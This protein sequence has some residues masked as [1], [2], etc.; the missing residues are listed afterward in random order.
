MSFTR[1]TLSYS[2]AGAL[3]GLT[4]ASSASAGVIAQT[5]T[6]VKGLKF[7][8]NLAA[9][10][11][12][13]LTTDFSALTFTDAVTNR[14]EVNG[15]VANTSGTIG[16]FVP[17]FNVLAA[18][19]GPSGY[20]ENSF[21]PYAVPPAANFSAADSFLAGA[22][23]ITGIVAVDTIGGG[24]SQTYVAT[25]LVSGGFLGSANS[26]NQLTTSLIFNLVGAVAA[27]TA[28][29]S[30][31]ADYFG[32]YYSTADTNFGTQ[33]GTSTRLSF[34]LTNAADA[35]I[36]SWT[37]G[38]TLVGGTLIADGGCANL[39]SSTPAGAANQQQV[40]VTCANA[41]YT[42]RISSALLQGVQYTLN[43]TQSSDV[44][45]K[46]AVPEPGSLALLGACLVGVGWVARRR[47]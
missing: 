23:I 18:T 19:V 34:S 1:K 12:F 39:N 45:A 41:L 16:V 29:I 22:P 40:P 10:D 25:S 38:G 44:N 43:I 11:I 7:F 46:L 14:A 24:L 4:I 33:G 17:S 6:T 3:L 32:Q 26:T 28:G 31:L 42:A 8:Q 2:V 35:T 21:T 47:A 5:T 37:P 13:N 36:F 30:F 20:I 9:S 15:T 27:D